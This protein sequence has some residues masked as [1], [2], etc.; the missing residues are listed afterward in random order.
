MN[1]KAIAIV[2]GIIGGLPAAGAGISW[3]LASAEDINDLKKI[4]GI[5]QDPQTVTAWEFLMETYR[6]DRLGEIEQ[7]LID[8]ENQ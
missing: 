3:L 4:I 7:R 8:L 6:E 5:Y 2:I 1:W